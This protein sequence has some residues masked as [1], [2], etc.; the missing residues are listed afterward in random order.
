MPLSCLTHC[1]SRYLSHHVCGLSTGYLVA[2][3]EAAELTPDLWWC[4]PEEPTQS[5][6][7]CLLGVRLGRCFWRE[8]YPLRAVAWW[9]E[10]QMLLGPQLACAPSDLMDFSMILRCQR[11]CLRLW[12]PRP[13][14]AGDTRLLH[15]L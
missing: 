9:W 6:L 3:Y 13:R 8:V 4:I 15:V 7:F 1:L 11:A 10:D 2:E 12:L 5:Y 14:A